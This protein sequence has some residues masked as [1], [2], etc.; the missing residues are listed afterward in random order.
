MS[1]CV[2]CQ[3]PAVTVFCYEC[4]PR[5]K[6][7]SHWGYFRTADMFPRSGDNKLVGRVPPYERDAYGDFSRNPGRWY[8]GDTLPKAPAWANPLLP[9]EEWEALT[10]C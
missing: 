4:G 5:F 10:S 8:P 7:L 9:R 1:R 6:S 3:G 2:H